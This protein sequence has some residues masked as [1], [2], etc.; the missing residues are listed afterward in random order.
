M[1]MTSNS[2]VNSSSK[3]LCDHKIRKKIH[4]VWSEEKGWLF[5]IYIGKKDYEK[6]LSLHFEHNKSR[7]FFRNEM[8]FTHSFN[9]E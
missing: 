3:T 9:E 1:M 5:M 4:S 7:K 6:R 2:L 8:N